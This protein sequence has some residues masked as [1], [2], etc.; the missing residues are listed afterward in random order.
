MEKEFANTL[1]V[2]EEEGGAGEGEREREEEGQK[3]RKE[4]KRRRRKQLSARYYERLSFEFTQ[5]MLT[6]N[7]CC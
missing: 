2:K 4:K 7:K 1:H 5:F 6:T 3:G